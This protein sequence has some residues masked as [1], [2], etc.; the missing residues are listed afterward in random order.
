MV[1]VCV[2][3]GMIHHG[4]DPQPRV[5]KALAPRSIPIRQSGAAV[6]R[7]ASPKPRSDGADGS[8]TLFPIPSAQTADAFHGQKLKLGG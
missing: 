4:A 3:H 5:S 6:A 2:P 7:Y 8:S 1:F